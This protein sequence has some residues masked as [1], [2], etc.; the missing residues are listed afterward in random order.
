MRL[1]SGKAVWFRPL[2]L[3]LCSIDPV[4]SGS[5][6]IDFREYGYLITLVT[7]NV[8]FASFYPVVTALNP[9]S[10][11]RNEIT[12]NAVQLVLFPPSHIWSLFSK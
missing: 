2:C 9:D 8:I 6:S 12:I 7:S 1:S 3:N 11:L 10:Y 4:S 5:F